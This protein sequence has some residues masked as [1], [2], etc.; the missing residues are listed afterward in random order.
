MS[1]ILEAALRERLAEMSSR[2]SARAAVMA[3]RLHID[4]LVGVLLNVEAETL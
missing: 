4:T 1:P 3:R 2:E